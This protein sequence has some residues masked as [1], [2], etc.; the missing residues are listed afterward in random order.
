MSALRSSERL[1]TFELTIVPP[2]WV[3]LEEFPTDGYGSPWITVRDVH[4]ADCLMSRLESMFG[5][6]EREA[7]LEMAKYYD[8]DSEGKWVRREEL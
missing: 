5:E 6:G 7:E 1:E 3:T 8:R 2:G 4:R